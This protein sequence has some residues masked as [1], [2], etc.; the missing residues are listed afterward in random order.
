[1]GGRLRHDR[2]ALGGVGKVL[3]GWGGLL[4]RLPEPHADKQRKHD[5]SCARATRRSSS[6]STRASASPSLWPRRATSF[7]S[8]RKRRASGLGGACSPWCSR[9]TGATALALG[10]EA[11]ARRGR[12]ASSSAALARLWWDRIVLRSARVRGQSRHMSTLYDASGRRAAAFTRNRSCLGSYRMALGG[13][14]SSVHRRGIDKRRYR[15]LD[16]ASAHGP[17]QRVR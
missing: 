1:M 2:V 4:N 13:M 16:C 9:W 8:A 15:L 3:G 14:P 10:S 5:R 17:P 7:S 6:T 12:L 11:D